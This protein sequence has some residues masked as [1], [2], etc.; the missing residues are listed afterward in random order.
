M[1]IVYYV[2][3]SEVEKTRNESVAYQSSL[4]LAQSDVPTMIIVIPMN[5]KP[6]SNMSEFD[7]RFKVCRCFRFPWM[8]TN[9]D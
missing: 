3:P 2:C 1:F 4:E 7:E 5:G 9:L 6:L 8:V